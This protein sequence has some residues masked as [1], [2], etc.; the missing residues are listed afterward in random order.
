MAAQKGKDLLLKI[1]SDGAGAFTTVAGLRSRTLAFNA[2]T[3][4]VTHQELAG[5]WRELLAARAY[6]TRASRGPASSGYRLGR[7]CAQRILRRPHPE[8]AGRDPGLRHCPRS[9]ADHI[10]RVLRPSRRRGVVRARA[11]LGRRAHLYGCLVNTGPAPMP[12]NK[13]RGEIEA[14]LDG[15]RTDCVSRWAR[16]PSSSWHSA[17]TTCWRSRNRFEKGRLKSRTRCASSAPA[18]AAPVSIFPTRRSPRCRQ[19]VGPLDLS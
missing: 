1:N 7:D 13:Y 14:T 9:V 17:M 15:S 4:D 11:R 19:R 8:L 12:A 5:L 2:E 18:C 16:S 10:A 3:V 6:A